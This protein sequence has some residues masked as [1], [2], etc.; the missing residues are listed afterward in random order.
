MI[1]DVM[2]EPDS[3]FYSEVTGNATDLLEAAKTKI[4][5]LKNYKVADMLKRS[6]RL[7]VAQEDVAMATA[8]ALHAAQ[9]RGLIHPT[10]KIVRAGTAILLYGEVLARVYVWNVLDANPMLSPLTNL[11]LQGMQHLQGK[12]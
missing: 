2:N 10:V 7:A 1:E 11:T 4:E 9:G 8:Q 6:E 12:R 5:R 3:Y